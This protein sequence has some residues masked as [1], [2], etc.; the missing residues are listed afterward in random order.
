M[1]LRDTY[2]EGGAQSAMLRVRSLMQMLATRL[3]EAKPGKIKWG[4]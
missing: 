1:H 4:I 2:D 3:N